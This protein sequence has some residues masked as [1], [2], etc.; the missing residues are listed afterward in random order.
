[1]GCIENGKRF[2]NISQTKSSASRLLRSWNYF[3]GQESFLFF[4]EF[5]NKFQNQVLSKK[6]SPFQLHPQ[7]TT[8]SLIRPV[9]GDSLLNWNHIQISTKYSRFM[10]FLIE[11]QNWQ[12]TTFLAD[13]FHILS[14]T[15][16]MQSSD[17]N[18]NKFHVVSTER[19]LNGMNISKLL[20]SF[21]SRKAF[22]RNIIQYTWCSSLNDS[23]AISM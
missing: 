23:K 9:V 2:I 21:E 10:A 20:V 12:L 7:N 11:L 15:R 13:G 18:S 19:G 22:G 4:I 14:I 17:Q 16:R 8:I 6:G 5:W 3:V 1:M